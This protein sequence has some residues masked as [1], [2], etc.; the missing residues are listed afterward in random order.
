MGFLFGYYCILGLSANSLKKNEPAYFRV[1]QPFRPCV[2]PAPWLPHLSQNCA[3]SLFLIRS[4]SRGHHWEDS[5]HSLMFPSLPCSWLNPGPLPLCLAHWLPYSAIH[6]L[7]LVVVS[8]RPT[9]AW[10]SA[11]SNPLVWESI[12]LS[13]SARRHF[14]KIF[15]LFFGYFI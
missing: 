6:S 1:S 11:E 8:P 4:T 13:C 14:K 12:S 15:Y 7:P 10:V 9:K 5:K 2:C 3:W